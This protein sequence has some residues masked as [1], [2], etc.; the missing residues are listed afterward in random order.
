MGKNLGDT[1]LCADLKEGKYTI[2]SH[3]IGYTSMDLTV[4]S[5]KTYFIREAINAGMFKTE[6]ILTPVGEAEG[7]AAVRACRLVESVM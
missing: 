5:G 7:R 2:T 3:F 6:T 4:E 1:Y